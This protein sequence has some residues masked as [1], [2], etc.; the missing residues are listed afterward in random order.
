MEPS[1]A[2]TKYEQLPFLQ[3]QDENIK[4][5][6]TLRILLVSDIHLAYS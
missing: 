4:V 2:L 5:L 1:M 6:E 3:K